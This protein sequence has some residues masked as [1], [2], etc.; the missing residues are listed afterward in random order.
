MQYFPLPTKDKI[1]R[2]PNPCDFFTSQSRSEKAEFSRQIRS[3]REEANSSQRL[4]SCWNFRKNVWFW[5]ASSVLQ[6]C[7]WLWGANRWTRSEQDQ[8]KEEIQGIYSRI[9][10]GNLQLSIPVN[11]M[12]LAAE[13]WPKVH[14]EN[15]LMLLLG[16]VKITLEIV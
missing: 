14:F 10:R 12:A 9:S 15:K 2:V 8:C 5:R 13:A 7:I 1:S 3:S 16:Q 11:K 4:I 6:R